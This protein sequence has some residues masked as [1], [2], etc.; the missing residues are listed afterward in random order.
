VI[1]WPRRARRHPFL[2]SS[3]GVAVAVDAHALGALAAA[4]GWRDLDAPRGGRAWTDD[5]TDVLGAV[6]WR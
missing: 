4:P 2:A 5:Y 6:R 1:A 3:V